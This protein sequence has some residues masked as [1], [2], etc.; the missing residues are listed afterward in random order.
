M[1]IFDKKKPIEAVIHFA[2]LKS[3]SE[4]IQYPEK[5]WN[6]NV[7]GSKVL[8]KIMDK[9][10]CRNIVFSSSATV[11]K[12]LGLNEFLTETAKTNPINPYG[13]KIRGRKF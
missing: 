11:Y 10:E 12:F 4:S 1:K 8:L 9:Y 5:Y 6:F 3:V 13:N 7:H 2:G